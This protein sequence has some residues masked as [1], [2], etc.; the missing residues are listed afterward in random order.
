MHDVRV[1]LGATIHILIL[2]Q[3]KGTKNTNTLILSHFGSLFF[4]CTDTVVYG[5]YVNHAPD[6]KHT[7]VY[8][9]Y[10]PQLI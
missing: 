6:I 3:Q 4:F 9:I 10:K 1:V 2:V 8:F 5:N 7:V